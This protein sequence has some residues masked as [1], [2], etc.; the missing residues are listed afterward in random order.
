MTREHDIEDIVRRL[1]EACVGHPH[2]KIEWPHRILHEAASALSSLAAVAKA[3]DEYRE[4]TLMLAKSEWVAR[5]RQK[6]FDAV[7]AL[8]PPTEG[9]E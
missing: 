2:A 5:A 8:P 7:A 1:R 6:L 3:A 4:L 9:G